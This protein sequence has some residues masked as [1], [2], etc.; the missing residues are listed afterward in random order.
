MAS[1]AQDRSNAQCVAIAASYWRKGVDVEVAAERMGIV[2]G[3]VEQWYRY[4]ARTA[5][6]YAAKV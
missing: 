6:E 5:D 2:V 1:G 4:F 3:Q